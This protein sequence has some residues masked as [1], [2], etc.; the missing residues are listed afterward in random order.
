[1]VACAASGASTALH[2]GGISL[3]RGTSTTALCSCSSSS[4]SSE[5]WIGLRPHNNGVLRQELGKQGRFRVQQ[6]GMRTIGRSTDGVV[7]AAQ[8]GEKRTPAGLGF[9]FVFF[10][11]GFFVIQILRMGLCGSWE[12]WAQFEDFACLDREQAKGST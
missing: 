9:L 1:M 11:L 5:A 7:R 6:Q 4:S 12:C 10:L 3:P 8:A 2:S